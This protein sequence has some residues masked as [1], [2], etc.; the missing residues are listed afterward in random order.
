MRVRFFFSNITIIIIIIIL[1]VTCEINPFETLSTP[2]I[3][4]ST[5]F[6][7]PASAGQRNLSFAAGETVDFACPGGNLVLE[8][9]T[10]TLEVAT[11]S[12]VSGGRFV[13]N[14]AR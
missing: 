8:G 3:I 10:T 13:I 1:A 11:G 9:V 14:N 4:Q 12:C 7:Y 6:V 2:L 5:S